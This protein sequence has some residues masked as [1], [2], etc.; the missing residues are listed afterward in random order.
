MTKQIKQLYKKRKIAFDLDGTII[1]HTKTAQQI[2]KKKWSIKLP[3][4]NCVSDMVRTKI[5][6]HIHKSLQTIIYGK[7][8]LKNPIMKDAKNTLKLLKNNNWSI[9]IVSRRYPE[10]R[11]FAL[12]WLNKNL[13]KIFPKENIFFASSIK[14]KNK[15]LKKININ[16]LV[17]DELKIIKLLSKNIKGIHFDQF[18][19]FNCKHLHVDIN[20]WKQI[21]TFL[22]INK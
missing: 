17:D 20:S 4:T 5:P 16:Y 2:L 9:Y 8:S 10:N 3:L 14:E 13:P 12:K 1:D 11:I 15:I 7:R 6:N 22:K 18:N 19:K 21:S